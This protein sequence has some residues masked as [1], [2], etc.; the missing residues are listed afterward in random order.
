VCILAGYLLVSGCSRGEKTHK[1]EEASTGE[2]VSVTADRLTVYYFHTNYR[3]R[4]CQQFEKLIKEVLGKDYADEISDG[5][6]ALE[7]VNVDKVKNE[8]FVDDYRL[9][10][11][12]L[13]LSLEKGGEELEWKNLDKIWTLVR[14]TETF[15]DYVRQGIDDYLKKVG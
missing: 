8:H 1:Q 13:I 10:T 15:K 2:S 6:V 12:S 7:L 5:V 9:M 11:K 4:T 3:C 14:D